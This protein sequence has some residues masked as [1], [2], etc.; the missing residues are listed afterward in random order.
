MRK[1]K[2]DIDLTKK[3]RKNEEIEYNKILQNFIEHK[4]HKIVD[5]KI[6]LNIT[7]YDK[8]EDREI[9]RKVRYY[10]IDD[11]NFMNLVND[12]RTDT[13]IGGGYYVT[14][15]SY[16]G[17]NSYKEKIKSI[18]IK[19]SFFECDI[20]LSVLNIDNDFNINKCIFKNN[21]NFNNLTFKNEQF[22]ITNSFMDGEIIS[23]S[24][25]N[26]LNKEFNINY[27]NCIKSKI[28]FYNVKFE[29]NK[30]EISNNRLVKNENILD[31]GFQ[32]CTL[33]SKIEIN[34]YNLNKL[35]IK[36][37]Y[38]EKSVNIGQGAD[39]VSLLSNI[40]LGHFNVL[41]YADIIRAI[42]KYYEDENYELS[43]KYINKAEEFKTLTK[44]YNDLGQYDNEDKAYV[45]HMNNLLDYQKEINGWKRCLDTTYCFR[46][47]TGRFGDYGTNPIKIFG[48]SLLIMV[49]F[50]IIYTKIFYI[51]SVDVKLDKETAEIL[52]ESLG[53]NFLNGLYFSGITFLTIGYGDINPA[54]INCSSVLLKFLTVAEGFIGVAMMSFFMVA[55]VRKV[56]R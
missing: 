2:V 31:I 23:F 22:K 25:V 21:L 41:H 49:Y 55:L 43:T 7:Y 40:I 50:G 14:Q 8:D 35:S 48:W 32:D 28:R 5:K 47:I 4:V 18:K 3:L 46:R 37:T 42:N 52:G 27:L 45:E 15:F 17:E 10:H 12:S 1:K 9:I 56:L 13:F 24:N 39:K 44:I 19:N 33:S 26:F 51:N 16:Q 36:K 20:N 6:I 34:I 54:S 29:N 38:I 30:V 11:K 53:G